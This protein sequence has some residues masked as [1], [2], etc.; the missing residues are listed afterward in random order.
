MEDKNKV[1]NKDIKEVTDFV[2]QPLSFEAKELLEEIKT[3]QKIVNYR[4]LK[5]KGGNMKAYDFSDY[6]TFKELFR[7][8]YYRNTTIDEA[9]SKQGKFNTLLHLLK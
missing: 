6:E 2:D 8:L 9:E 4:K 5:I 3:I 1:E 7:D